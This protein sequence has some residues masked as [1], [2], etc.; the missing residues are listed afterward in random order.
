MLKSKTKRN[1]FTITSFFIAILIG[2]SLLVF[3]LNS[4]QNKVRYK[5]A[6]KKMRS[7]LTTLWNYSISYQRMPPAVV[8][9]KDGSKCHSWR[10]VLYFTKYQQTEASGLPLLSYDEYHEC[11]DLGEMKIWQ[12]LRPDIFCEANSNQTHVFAVLGNDTAW[13]SGNSTVLEDL[14]EDLIVFVY[15]S[16][17]AT[18][19]IIPNEIELNDLI[20]NQHRTVSDILGSDFIV[21]F[22]DEQVWTLDAHTPISAL[23][24]FLTVT[25]AK[26]NDRN[27]SLGGYRIL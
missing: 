4:A 14:P 7:V 16:K 5:T 9:G 15:S 26:G 10:F 13:D 27:E 22:A 17:K 11:R 21:G 2:V 23:L 1:W 20:K 8:N 12:E 24:P 18:D 19:W 25:N 3:C 6:R